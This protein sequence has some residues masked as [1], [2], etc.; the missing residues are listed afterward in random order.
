MAGWRGT[1]RALNWVCMLYRWLAGALVMIAVSRWPWWQ[2]HAGRPRPACLFLSGPG[3]LSR[4]LLS[5]AL[6]T[7]SCPP[8]CLATPSQPLHNTSSMVP[9]CNPQSWSAASILSSP[10]GKMMNTLQ[11]LSVPF[12]YIKHNKPAVMHHLFLLQP[13]SIMSVAINASCKTT[14]IHHCHPKMVSYETLFPLLRQLVQ[15]NNDIEDT[16]IQYPPLL[17]QGACLDFIRQRLGAQQ[18]IIRDICDYNLTTTAPQK[19]EH[20]S[21]DVQACTQAQE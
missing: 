4:Q 6:I 5:P 16:E 15:L 2:L 19:L 13:C 21:A 1:C 20:S 14:L 7:P 10:V 11:P 8:C 9:Q 17:I 18:L 12:K 3:T